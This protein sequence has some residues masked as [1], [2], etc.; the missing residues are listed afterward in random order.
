[1]R[2]RRLSRLGRLHGAILAAVLQALAPAIAAAHAFEH[3]I[4]DARLAADLG[5]VSHD[6]LRANPPIHEHE[7]GESSSAACGVCKGHAPL[8]PVLTAENAVASILATCTGTPQPASIVLPTTTSRLCA[9]PRAP[10]ASA[11]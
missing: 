3:E 6:A 7:N 8:T 1:M 2:A 4:H 9:A 11:S 5:D 10:P